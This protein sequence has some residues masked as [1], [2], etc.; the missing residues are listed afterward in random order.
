MEIFEKLDLYHLLKSKRV[1]KKINSKNEFSIKPKN[2]ET[3]MWM[4]YF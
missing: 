3:I 1:I 4:K 2:L